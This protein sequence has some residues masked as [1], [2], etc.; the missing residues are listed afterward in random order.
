MTLSYRLSE[1]ARDDYAAIY[2]YTLSSFGEDQAEQYTQGLL[3]VFELITEHT[4]IG[5]HVNH[6]RKGYFR[7]DYEHHSIYY[8]ID[9]EGVLII[10]LLAH[11]QKPPTDK[12][13][14][15]PL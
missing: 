13:F 3:D 4:H 12:D 9:H 7:Y 6:L 5:R 11:R 14:E 8:T 10:R 2:S 15:N 1:K